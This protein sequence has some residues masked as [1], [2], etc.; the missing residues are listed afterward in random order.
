MAADVTSNFSA[1]GGVAHMDGVLQ[2]KLF[3]ESGKIVGVRVHIVAVPGLGG[4]AGAS[5]VMSNDAIPA[6]TEE[7]HLSIPVI[8]GER[9]PVTEHYG[10]ARSPVLVEN[11]GTVFG[12]NGTHGIVCLDCP[13]A[14]CRTTY[15]CVERTVR[16]QLIAEFLCCTHPEADKDRHHH[17]L[18]D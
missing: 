2:V 9:P 10:L 6:L 17:E 4:T 14:I 7:K 11:L 16:T 1:P 18:R 12:P 3:S 15:R 13:S 8:G 5:P